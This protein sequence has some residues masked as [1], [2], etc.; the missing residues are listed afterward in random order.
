MKVCHHNEAL[1]S[2]QAQQVWFE[3]NSLSLVLRDERVITLP[4]AQIPWLLW[5]A[6]ATSEDRA[7][8]S[9]E[10]DGYAVYWHSL[11]DG[12]EVIHV[13]NE[14]ALL[15]TEIHSAVGDNGTLSDKTLTT[16]AED[17][18]LELDR[19]EAGNARVQLR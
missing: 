6:N 7:D 15:S 1:P 5:L 4:I 13:L 19:T 3:E 8:W 16:I 10:P 11:D 12:F 17:S 14:L 2:Y 18:F 9:I